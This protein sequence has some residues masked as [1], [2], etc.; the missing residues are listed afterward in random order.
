[1]AIMVD[2][3]SDNE[4]EAITWGYFRRNL[5]D[6]CIVYASRTVKTRQYDLCVLIPEKALFI[7]EVKGWSPDYIVS[8]T[9]SEITLRDRTSKNPYNQA[10]GYRY[11]MLNKI[12]DDLSLNPLVLA[13]VCYPHLSREDYLAKRLDVVS[14]EEVTLFEE[15]LKDSVK[16]LGKFQRCFDSQK[17]T[18]HDELTPKNVAYIRHKLEPDFDINGSYAIH[19]GYSRLRVLPSGIQGIE[20]Q[21]IVREYFAG[22]KEYVFV[23]SFNDMHRILIEL[24]SEFSKHNLRPE[25]GNIRIGKYNDDIDTEAGSYRIFN[26]E[27]YC[28]EG[29]SS[30]STEVLI[31]EGR[32]NDDQ[33]ELLEQLGKVTEFNIQQYFVEHAPDDVNVLV[34]A[35]AG[36]GK[37]YSMVSRIAYLCNRSVDPIADFKDDIAMIT[38]TND[39][40]DN[41][42]SRIKKMLMN[43]FI[44]TG[45]EKYAQIIIDL[46]EAQIS[47]IHKF[48]ISILHDEC[49]GFGLS[50]DSEVAS[51]IF[52]RRNFYRFYLNEYYR[53]NMEDNPDF[54]KQIFF[55]PKE[56]QD[57]M[58]SYASQ[59]YNRN[60]DICRDSHLTDVNI[61]EMPYFHDMLKEIAV[62]A[63]KDYQDFL[64]NMN[65]IDLKKCILMA[66]EFLK[67]N[68]SINEKLRYKYI[69]VDEFQDTDDIQIETVL[70]IQKLCGPNTMLFIVGDLKQSIYR[71]RGATL[72]AFDRAEKNGGIWNEYYLTRN[73][74]TDSTLLERFHLVFEKMA[75]ENSNLL[76]YGKSDH[77]VSSLSKNI[78][79]EDPDENISYVDSDSLYDALAE[80]IRKQ[81]DVTEKLDSISHLSKEE[82]TIAILVRTN[83][84]VRDI[85]LKMLKEHIQV[86]TPN[87][88]NLYEL[89]SSLDLLKLVEALTNPLNI[90][91]LANLIRSDY[92]SL[93]TDISV[94][95]GYSEKVKREKLTALLDQYFGLMM[96]K[97]WND[98]IS[99]CQVRPVLVVLREIYD[100]TKPWV[101]CSDDERVRR[102]YQENYDLLI[103][104]I[105]QFFSRDY[106]TIN[107]I[108]NYLTIHITKG[109]AEESRAEENGKDIRIVCMTVHKA[110]G[111]EFGTVLLPFSCDAI[112]K[113]D[114][115]ALT[116]NVVENKV[117]CR[118]KANGEYFFT[119]E[120]DDSTEILETEKEEARILYVAM[121][122]AIRKF[123][124]FEKKDNQNLSWQSYLEV[125]DH[126][127]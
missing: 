73:Y 108:C 124:W 22:T 69:F 76:P 49:T 40:A 15:D 113:S 123:I 26:F 67:R 115:G 90:E 28:L 116:V 121:T 52:D 96:K 95:H 101:H 78:T 62:P 42:K 100:A 99:D 21:Q 47:T 74:R 8:V 12:R 6:D 89:Q 85:Q 63:E 88:G 46:T 29:K 75:S 87:A 9:N 109:Q 25:R 83:R 110:K 33:K 32:Y 111:L 81:V 36:T 94:L 102:L 77:L 70:Q 66:D 27:L 11:A 86:E 122:R 20:I 105:T 107:M 61:K 126:V 5:P 23:E 92:V 82:K 14:E 118:V 13:M 44:L 16:L 114:H 65:R 24:K 35:G 18:E 125:L 1:M 3:K 30:I 59:L 97:S 72:S 38:F 79:G 53:K 56:C 45:K 39:A 51:G 54:Q 80:Q 98:L 10:L 103:E 60:M 112:D 41:M 91:Y 55:S 71:F 4:G 119:D 64:D 34:K 68:G 48:A 17:S 19:P 93:K 57:V 58:I 127:D 120:F 84:Q 43:Y 7:V 106:L 50:N 2:K 31:E 37:T 104:K 117:S